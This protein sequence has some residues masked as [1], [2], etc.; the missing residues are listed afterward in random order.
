MERQATHKL[1]VRETFVR[2]IESRIL[3]GELRPGDRLPTSRELCAQ[4]GVSLT[5]VN[6]G[7]AEL[8]NKGFVDVKP[9]H[10]VY[11]ADYETK[12]NPAMLLAII[13]YNGGRLNPHD[14]RSFCE[15]RMALDPM[16]AELAI[17]RARDAE[18]DEWG[19]M[20]PILRTEEDTG[21]FCTLI[22]EYFH[23]LYRM[24]DN[25]ILSLLF[26]STIEPQKRM[27]ETFIEKNGRELILQN[28]EEIY[29]HVKARDCEAAARCMRETMRLPLEGSTAII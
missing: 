21:M 23:K 14:V 29:S 10:G 28:A 15:S 25:S 19:S 22:T 3:S 26:Y 8:Q 17:R 20:L 5:I 1:T 24:S 6:A 7:I 11:V 2:E 27:Y 12:G 9:R 16:A 18:I 4:M 13:Q